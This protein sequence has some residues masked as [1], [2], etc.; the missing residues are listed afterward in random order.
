[1]YRRDKELQ[2]DF[3]HPDIACPH[4]FPEGNFYRVLKEKLD[5]WV[6]ELDF[7]PLYCPDNGRPAASPRALCKALVLQHL[8]NLSDRQLEEACRYDLRFKYVL[9]LPLDDFGFDHSLFGRFRDR[10]L[11]NPG[12]KEAL[13]R[14]IELLKAEG[15]IKPDEPQRVDA[16]HVVANI[17]VPSATE[18]IRQCVRQLLV[19]MKRKA[20]PLFKAFREDKEELVRRYLEGEGAR[21]GKGRL[22]PAEQQERLLTVVR[23]AQTILAWLEEQPELHPAVAFAKE[24]L[25]RALYQNIEPSADGA[26]YR[27]QGE[28]HPDRLVSAVDPDARHGAKSGKKKF[29]GYKV[30]HLETTESRFITNVTVTPGNA[31]DAEPVVELVRES[32]E[33]NDLKPSK[34]LGDG[35]HGTG[36]NRRALA[37]EGVM[38]VAPPQPRALAPELREGRF[39]FDPDTETLTCPAGVACRHRTYNP[40]AES[41]VYRFPA[42]ACRACELK[43]SC[44]KGRSSRIITVSRYYREHMEAYLY[45][46][47]PAYKQDMRVRALIE[48]KNG[49]LARWHG[50]RRARY[51]GLV[52]TRLQAIFTALAINFKRWVHLTIAA[53]QAV[54]AAAA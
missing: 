9:G 29:T 32:K 13:F 14:Q 19:K 40:Q 26:G 17:A 23:D 44:T 7:Q 27:E 52:K 34:V 54:E 24:L 42:A 30:H 6:D 28:P 47:T 15:H 39:I 46:Q 3:Y 36:A 18:L 41:W 11:T 21:P 33:Q 45:S 53:K 10:L 22:T 35:A 16:T 2:L 49:E 20:N 43:G 38:L 50:L 5:R 1:M 12:Y 51:W 31:H 48:P 37:E 4:L 25:L 8:F